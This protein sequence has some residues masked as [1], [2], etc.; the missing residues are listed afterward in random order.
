MGVTLLTLQKL[1]FRLISLH[2]R[3]VRGFNLHAIT[4]LCL[5]TIFFSSCASQPGYMAS[6]STTTAV[7][8]SGVALA[9]VGVAGAGGYFLGQKLGGSTGGIL[10]LL[11]GA[12]IAFGLEQF[13]NNKRMDSYLAGIKDGQD[14]KR[15]EVAKA[16]YEREAIYGLPVPWE[17]DLANNPTIRNVYVPSRTVDGVQYKGDYQRVPVYK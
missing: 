9:G 4:W 7:T 5:I 11:A 13:Y 6:E 2:R 16:I 12:G 10:G 14:A 15:A 3:R 8:D 17:S 1:A